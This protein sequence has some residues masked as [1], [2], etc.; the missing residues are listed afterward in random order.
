MSEL[1]YLI[2]YIIAMPL[3]LIWK[4]YFYSKVD[5]SLLDDKYYSN[6]TSISIG[7]DIMWC[8]G[9]P[10]Y[11]FLAVIVLLGQ[12]SLPY[13]ENKSD[14]K[15]LKKKLRKLVKKKEK[16]DKKKEKLKKKKIKKFRK[17]LQKKVK[18]GKVNHRRTMTPPR[19][20]NTY[21]EGV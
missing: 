8:L 7:R 13:L 5:T 6:K 12:S 10:L 1:D 17:Q 4:S 2:I 18:K 20:D 16:E 19:Y 14:N 11:S 3:S 15:Y 9:W 21:F